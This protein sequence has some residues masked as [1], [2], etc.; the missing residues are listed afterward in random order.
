L[1]TDIHIPELHLQPNPVRTSAKIIVRLT[2][3]SH[4]ELGVYDVKGTLV[5][6]VFKGE[7]HAGTHEFPWSRASLPPGV[8]HL[9]LNSRHARLDRTFML[10]R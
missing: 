3:E 8:Y 10:L 7:L 4:I 2:E 5:S 1:T 6:H 9:R